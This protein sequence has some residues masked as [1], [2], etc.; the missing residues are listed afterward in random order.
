[1]ALPS[2]DE[3][4]AA[5]RPSETLLLDHQGEILY[6]LRTD[7]RSRRLGWVELAALPL[8]LRQA[9]VR[10][11]DQRFYEHR[12]VDYAALA[13][14]GVK[15]VFSE[16][17]RGASTISM[18]L[19][20]LLD[21]DLQPTH[22]RRSLSQKWRQIQAG[23]RL[24]RSWSKDQILEA[25]LNLVF[26]RGENQGVAS[27]SRSLFGKAPHGLDAAESCALAALIRSP[28]ADS[29]QVAGRALQI[30]RLLNLRLSD[31]AIRDTVMWALREPTPI[32]PREELAPHAARRLLK[33]HSGAATV[34]CTLDAELQRFVTERLAHHLTRLTAQHVAEGAALIVDNQ[35]GAVRAYA[36][37]TTEPARSRFVDGVVA[38]RQAGSTLKPFLYALAFDRRIL[39][40]ASEVEDG[41]LDVAGPAGIYQPRNYDGSHK[42][43]VSVREA[44]ASSLNIPAVRTAEMVGIDLFLGVLSDL[45]VRE[46]HEFAEFFGPS[47]ALGTADVSLWELV[48]A[49]R[50]L[51]NGGI[52]R[53]MGLEAESS[54]PPARRVFS[55]EATFLVSDILSDREA[56]RLTFGLESVLATRFWT[57]VKTG[58]SKD[59]R[60]NWCIGYSRRFTV[61]V[62]IGN[63]SGEPMWDVSGLTGAAPLWLEMMNFVH[64]ADTGAPARPPAGLVRSPVGVGESLSMEW[65]I[66]GTEPAPHGL[67]REPAVGRIA[68][69][70]AG[71]VFALDPDIPSGRQ[72]I[73]FLL[74]GRS[75]RL[76]W[77]LNG[78]EL[79]PAG[80]ALS[81]TPEAGR[82]I[83]ALTDDQGATI[84]T[85]RFQVK[86]RLEQTD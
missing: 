5:F 81:W 25:Y 51:A 85:V 43:A 9:V 44:L 12:G 4:R 64:G 24:E 60:D 26:F 19:A 42:G 65:F 61:G 73:A 8:V 30:G 62:W 54:R 23:M 20:A 34:F 48:N 15:G 69:P 17:R 80:A 27:A 21:P 84:D 22:G 49:Y 16:N 39:T 63:F 78:R 35:T 29:A 33:G 55:E 82:Y 68:Y 72:R 14:A 31:P 50:A 70:P 1:M 10:A 59:M 6:E 46:L 38:K 71:A 75:D 3:V 32:R 40:P 79:G 76:R 37:H 11:E 83:L 41:P 18:Q 86:G 2:Y 36:S 13:A 58:T 57:A 53:A 7:R 56:R 77:V 45:G 28:N 66:R 74:Q 52:W 47:I 67:D